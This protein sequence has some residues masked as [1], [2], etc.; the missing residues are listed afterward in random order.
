M[1]FAPFAHGPMLTLTAGFLIAYPRP[2]GVSVLP[3]EPAF[4]AGILG[5]STAE[6]LLILILGAF[7]FGYRRAWN[8]VR[9][10]GRGVK[11]IFAGLY[12][13]ATAFQREV[14]KNL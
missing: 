2:Q 14:S 13:G 7:L 3:S 10:I 4:A 12:K 6:F 5:I 1:Q 9:K 8:A 11:V